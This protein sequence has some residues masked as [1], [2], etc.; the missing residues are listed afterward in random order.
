MFVDTSKGAN[1]EV[2]CANSACGSPIRKKA[3]DGLRG[4]LGLNSSS[5]SGFYLGE[6]WLCSEACL[7]ASVG[8][9]ILKTVAH[10]ISESLFKP[11]GPRIGTFLRARGWLNSDQLGEALDFQGEHKWKLGKCL[12][13]LGYL[14]E[15]KLLTALSEQLK[16]PCINGPISSAVETALTSVPKKICVQFRV[17]PFEFHQN[18]IL[19]VAVDI[20][21]RE[22]VILAMQEVLGCSVQPYL[23]TNEAVQELL[24]RFI[25]PLPEKSVSSVGR[26]S[27][28]AEEVGRVFFE[29]W[30]HYGARKARFAAL[31]K[32]IWLR[33]LSP[34]TFHDHFLIPE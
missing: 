2:R 34:D 27:Q 10:P 33:Y 15:Q 5:S 32:T 14:S 3:L 16:V 31:E 29:Q 24:E 7:Q 9:G 26:V 17:V 19:R 28:S 25:L 6:Q 12:M 21:L 13:E 22:R 18:H 4:W 20:D 1:R 8:A 23:T 11:M 30:S